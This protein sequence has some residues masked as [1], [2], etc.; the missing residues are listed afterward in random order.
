MSSGGEPAFSR[1]VSVSSHAQRALAAQ[2]PSTALGL[3]SPSSSFGR[4]SGSHRDEMPP[5]ETSEGTRPW[6]STG[7]F[8]RVCSTQQMTFGFV[9]GYRCAF[10]ASLRLTR[11]AFA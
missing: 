1:S 8:I 7:V 6:V 9:L 11:E 5:G 4:R 10:H 2:R 3:Y